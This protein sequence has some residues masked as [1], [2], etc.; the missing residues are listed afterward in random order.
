MLDR[1]QEQPSVLDAHL[2][3][4]V[5]PLLAAMRLVALGQADRAA[6]PHTARVVYALCKV[7]GY[8][9]IIR[10]VPHEVADLEPLVQLLGSV[11]PADHA[12]WQVRGC[13]ATT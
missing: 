9:T 12:N 5:T 10:F 7:R 3:V 8:K 13:R 2:E 11:D 6:L 1:Y 4:M